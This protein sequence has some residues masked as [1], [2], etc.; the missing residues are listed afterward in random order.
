MSR[1][2]NRRLERKRR[3]LSLSHPSPLTTRVK[4]RSNRAPIRGCRVTWRA[5]STFRIVGKQE[6]KKENIGVRACVHAHKHKIVIVPPGS[7]A[8]PTVI[9]VIVSFHRAEGAQGGS[10]QIGAARGERGGKAATRPPC[11]RPRRQERT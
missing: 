9:V 1:R 5:P 4:A 3:D 2:C 8:R 11:S 7:R 10:A 6:R